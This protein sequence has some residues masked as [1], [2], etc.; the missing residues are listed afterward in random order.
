MRGVRLAIVLAAVCPS[1]LPADG[2]NNLPRDAVEVSGEGIYYLEGKDNLA[3]ARSMAVGIARSNAIESAFGTALS[4]T[5]QYQAYETAEG[6]S[7][8][9]F[10]TLMRSVQTG[11]WVRDLEE[12]EVTNF[13]GED[14]IFGYKAK[15]RGLVRPLMSMPV[16]TRGRVF[17]DKGKDTGLT[18]ESS[19]I[20]RGDEFFFGFIAASDGFLAVY[21]VDENES[22]CKAAPFG[23]NSMPLRRIS[24]EKEAILRDEYMKNLAEISR[25]ES[26]E[27][28]NR[29]VYVFSPNEFTLPLSEEADPVTG[30]PPVMDLAKFHTWLQDMAVTDPRFTVSWQTI[31]IKR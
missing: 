4:S 31:A 13:M 12:P 23:R 8:D 11:I 24:A 1:L 2:M 15:V 14:D 22:V 3:D 6:E 21:V 18:Y 20:R 29:V 7:S 17:V 26:R 25:P 10:Y 5:S 30:M 9:S 28:F 19:T 16:E 27:V